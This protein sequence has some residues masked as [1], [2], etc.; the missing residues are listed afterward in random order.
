[1]GDDEGVLRRI[2]AAC[3]DRVDKD[4]GDPAARDRNS[5]VRQRKQRDEGQKHDERGGR[6]NNPAAARRPRGG[7]SPRISSSRD[8]HCRSARLGSGGKREIRIKRR[9]QVAHG[10]GRARAEAEKIEPVHGDER[11]IG[12]RGRR[13]EGGREKMSSLPPTIFPLVIL[14]MTSGAAAITPSSVIGL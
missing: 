2:D 1:M 5:A 13:R 8:A 7:A 12:G 9:H 10:V 11:A 4:L 6:Q 14:R 3:L